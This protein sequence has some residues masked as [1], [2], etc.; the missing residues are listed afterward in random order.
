MSWPNFETKGTNEREAYMD[1]H[2]DIRLTTEELSLLHQL[3]ALTGKDENEILDIALNFWME[4]LKGIY[5]TS[6][7][8]PLMPLHWGIDSW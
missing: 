3:H 4:T 7:V 6:D 2:T 8:E 1:P 5:E